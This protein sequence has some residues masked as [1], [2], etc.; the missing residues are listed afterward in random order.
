MAKWLGHKYSLFVSLQKRVNIAN[1]SH[2]MKGLIQGWP[3][4][5]SQN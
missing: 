4:L 3:W 5:V 1:V 2:P